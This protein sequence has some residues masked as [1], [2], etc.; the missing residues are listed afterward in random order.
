MSENQIETS[1]EVDVDQETAFL[2][3][4]EEMN[5]WWKQGAI[6]FHDASRAFENR[7]EPGIGGRIVEV[8][9]ASTGDGFELRRITEW[10]PGERVAWTSSIDEVV[11]DVRF[12]A[13]GAKRTR[14]LV[15]ATIPEGGDRGGSSWCRMTPV[16]FPMWIEERDTAPRQPVALARLAI[17]I[18][19]D[20]PARAGRFLRDV[21]KFKCAGGIPSEEPVNPDECWIEFHAGNASIIALASAEKVDRGTSHEPWVF[22]DDLDDLYAHIDKNGQITQEIWQHGPR[23]FQAADSEGNRWT[24]AQATPLMRAG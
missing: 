24:F 1:V 6:N 2:A 3:F 19:Y 10:Q 13:V 15:I 17:S 21:F 7:I 20:E 14:V 12:E 18:Y 16:W 22:V 23:A 8:H 5:C 4:T 11:T 9:D